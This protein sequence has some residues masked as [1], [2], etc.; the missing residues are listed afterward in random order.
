MRVYVKFQKN[1]KVVWNYSLLP[2][3]RPEMKILSIWVN[4]Y[5]KFNIELFSYCTIL[6]EI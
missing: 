3:L 5:K 4:N 6:H 1:L 2:N